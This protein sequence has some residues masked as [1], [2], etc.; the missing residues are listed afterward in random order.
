M[1][2]EVW[3]LSINLWF[4]FLQAANGPPDTF[5]MA[6]KLLSKFNYVECF[7]NFFLIIHR[8]YTWQFL[9]SNPRC[10]PRKRLGPRKRPARKLDLAR[11]QQ[12][13]MAFQSLRCP[14]N[15]SKAMLKGYKRRYNDYYYFLNKCWHTY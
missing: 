12:S 14:R 10:H 1:F 2:K 4:R 15:N 3:A 5:W 6:H 9:K 13:L 7:Y 11:D 8:L